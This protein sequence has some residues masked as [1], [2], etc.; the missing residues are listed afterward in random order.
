MQHVA[1]VGGG[2]CL[3]AETVEIIS[4]TIGVTLKMQVFFRCVIWTLDKAMLMPTSAKMSYSNLHIFI[5]PLKFQISFLQ[6]I[7]PAPTY[8]KY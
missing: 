2:V 4:I 3:T 6:E 7:K 1:N 5:I 8:L